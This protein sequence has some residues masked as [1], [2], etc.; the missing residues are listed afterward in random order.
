MSTPEFIVRALS[1]AGLVCAL[2]WLFIVLR[3][4]RED[5]LDEREADLVLREESLRRS[6]LELQAKFSNRRVLEQEA[7]R[8]AK[9][10]HDDLRAGWAELEHEHLVRETPAG[11]RTLR[12]AANR[13]GNRGNA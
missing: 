2:A 7:D 12:P 5:D 3:G 11:V 9:Q 6:L 13:Y 1:I 4:A 8:I 10:A